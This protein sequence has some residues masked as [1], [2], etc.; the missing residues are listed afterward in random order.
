MEQY[1]PPPMVDNLRQKIRLFLSCR[2]L[3]DLD[4]ITVSDPYIEIWL[5]NDERSSWTKI[6]QTE[7]I[8]NNLNPDFATPVVLDYFFEKSQEIRFEVYD[9]DVNGRDEIG[10]CTTRLSRLL[11]A[12]NQTFTEDLKY[13]KKPKRKNG[14][15]VVT[16]DSVKDSNHSVNIRLRCEGLKSKTSFFGFLS[17]NNPFLVIRR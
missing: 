12:K 17:T 9:K 1:A 15:I 14:Q 5:K 3:A 6:A 7:T 13:A 16:V 11:S 4:I 2:N 10:K 8:D